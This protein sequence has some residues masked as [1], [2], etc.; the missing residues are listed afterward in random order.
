M[1][2]ISL[3][4]TSGGLL[5][6]VFMDALRQTDADSTTRVLADPATFTDE[7]GKPPT[8]A[9]YENDVDAALKSATALW[10]AYHDEI[11]A[12][13]DVSRLRDRVLI[14]F[15]RNL[16]FDPMYQRSHATAGDKP[17]AISHLG[18]DGPNAP[19]MILVA[20]DDL[21]ARTIRG[22]SPHEHLQGFLNNGPLL[23]GILTNGRVLRVLRDYHHTRSRGYV[24]ASLTAIFDAGSL[25]D[26]LALYRVGHASRFRPMLSTVNGDLVE[27]EEDADEA[28]A[29]VVAEAA[30]P[31]MLLEKAY[32]ENLNAGVAAGKR[33]QPQ[34]RDGMQTLANGLLEAT[35]GLRQRLIDNP[36]EGRE[37]YREILTVLYRILFLLFAEQ[38]HMLDGAAPIYQQTY[39]LASLRARAEADNAEPRRHDLWE[40]LKT[41]FRLFS[42]PEVAATV[43]VYPYNGQLFNPARTPIATSGNCDNKH[44]LDVIRALTTV[45]SGRMRM[46]VD[47]RNLGVE[48]LGTVYE[49]LLDYTLTV[50]PIGVNSGGRA[51]PA[52]HAYLAPLSTERADLASYYTPTDLV[53]LLLARS[54]DPFIA[55]R[56]ATAGDDKGSREQALLSLKVI[57]PACGSAA[58]LIGALDRIATALAGTRSAP[59]EPRD[60]ELAL[61]RRD[62]LQRCIYGV[63]K[64]RFAVELAKVALWIHCVVPD[65]P[66]SFLDNRIVCGDALVG[67]PLLDLP[68]EIGLGAFDFK[69]A[70][71]DKA[72]LT[73]A[74][75]RNAAFVEESSLLSLLAVTPDLHVPPVLSETDR[76]FEDVRKKATAFEAWKGSAEY[77]R[78][79]A[80]ADVWTAA[81]FWTAADGAVP[82][83]DE[84]RQA[85]EGQ[86]DD[87][88]AAAA[89]LVSADL[90]PLH[91]PLAFP[92]VREAGGFDVVLSNPPWQESASSEQEFF[93]QSAPHIAAMTSEHRA[94]AIKALE[95]TDPTLF[96]RWVK[97]QERQRRF[98]HFCKSSGR[99]TRTAGKVNTYVAFTDLAAEIGGQSGLIVKSGIATDE[100]QSPV[101]RRLLDSGRVRLVLDMVNT[102]PSGGKVFQA[103]AAVERFS[104]LTLGSPQ[105][106]QAIQAAMLN[107][108]PEQASDAT[109]RMWPRADL[110]AMSPRTQ[111]LPSSA[112]SGEI[113]VALRLQR[114]FPTLDFADGR[115]DNPWKITV[116]ELYNSS[117]MKTD[118]LV[119]RSG[120][121]VREGFEMS[122]DKVF[123]HPD[124]REAVAV[125]EGQMVNRWDHR[126]RT[127]E[128]YTGVDAK[129][130]GKKPHIP[131]V[132]EEQHQDAAFEV[133]P[134]YWMHRDVAEARIQK[135]AGEGWIIA[136]REIG[137][138][139][140]NRRSMRTA[141]VGRN[142]AS[143]TL[144]VIVVAPDRAFFLA[145]LFNSMTFDFLVRM[146][147]P[148]GHITP[149]VLSQCAAPDPGDFAAVVADLGAS[150]S[151]TSGSLADLSGRDVTTWDAAERQRIDAEL[152]AYVASA[153]GLSRDEYEGVLD[154]FVL[155]RKIEEKSTNYG[156]YRSKRLRLEAFDKIG[157]TS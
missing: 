140:T 6:D 7:S 113:D 51:V 57:D 32:E 122:R 46:H 114:G 101:W 121:L 104:I 61:A 97:Y 120:D 26:F 100:A 105:G 95:Q 24:E 96:G 65:Q 127:F 58:I 34:V 18:W 74:K 149:W 80:A 148:G 60:T 98:A 10:S 85:V 68:S 91:W 25:P 131:W 112:S 48:E 82:T 84:Y 28:V 142:P 22:L 9:Q 81:F 79:K 102:R 12:G 62:V 130:Y 124:G 133:E 136:M 76:S 55:D 3:I 52:G 4:H 31:S 66:L 155:L 71:A 93:A 8:R 106:G 117:K 139:W 141:L 45:P 86:L 83:T 38:R 99:F 150:L 90:N 1:S 33:L 126:S 47:Y 13:M 92:D 145:S 11:E 78:W 16:G 89:E 50:T 118:G 17:W 67:W 27:S 151:V 153:Y 77:L 146:H 63:D 88:V 138:V 157:E 103:P 132:T 5:G 116:T 152:D 21:D 36:D 14:P 115:G 111:T 44:V 53:D 40:G 54:L 109:P 108:G 128:G 20:D 110:L 2:D 64:D 29:V 87:A 147:M 43:G 123:R 119:V 41:T 156:E 35:P 37:F 42:D 154:H 39:S 75:K 129:R 49:S 94:Q 59:Q 135:V 137:A 70:A 30:P 72:V 144:P 107:F 56:L 23:W 15:L 19:P 73:A 125:L 143:D 69:A 134:R